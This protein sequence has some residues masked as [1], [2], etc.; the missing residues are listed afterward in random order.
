MS[1]YQDLKYLD[2]SFITLS[3]TKY[4]NATNKI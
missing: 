4:I 1:N 3:T 2:I